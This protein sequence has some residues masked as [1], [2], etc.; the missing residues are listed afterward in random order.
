MFLSKLKSNQSRNAPRSALVFDF[1]TSA[2]KI[3][4]CDYFDDRVE[5]VGGTKVKFPKEV[6]GE[7]GTITQIDPLEKLL[8]ASI[9]ALVNK[10]KRSRPALALLG[11][12]DLNASGYTSKINYRRAHPERS[13]TE[14]EF[15]N[16]LRQVEMRANQIMQKMIR[17]QTGDGETAALVNSEVLDL[18]LDGY[19]IASPVGSAG[20]NL[21]FTVYNAYTKE[22]TLK[23]LASLFRRL[24]FSLLSISCSIYPAMRALLDSF[25]DDLSAVVVDIG[26]E[27]TDV[28]VIS[29]GRIL[30]HTAFGIAGSAFSKTI[31]EAMDLDIERAEMLKLAF[32]GG[33]LE[34]NSMKD[35]R[36]I[37]GTD[38]KVFLSGVELVLK[39]FPGI[40]DLPSQV[41]VF[42]GGSLLPGVISSFQTYEWKQF[43][44]SS[45]QQLKVIHLQPQKLTG[46]KDL[47]TKLISPA[48]V[49]PLAVALDGQ[50]LVLEAKTGGGWRA[51]LKR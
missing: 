50:D 30:G 40:R 6:F 45:D 42:G 5:V 9:A 36:A 31:A 25:G 35:V 16:I 24:K 19:Q 46:F 26:G 18:K 23:L 1:G 37:V 20:K 2:V 49:A 48:D 39:D 43:S 13:I 38:C 27:I 51:L 7:E 14:A 28:G 4:L 34:N 3:L 47:T 44:P 41:V 33:K 32:A 11:L 8:D 21:V 12:S 10:A 22:Q 29:K 17:W 15:Q